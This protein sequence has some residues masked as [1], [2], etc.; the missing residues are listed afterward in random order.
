MMIKLNGIYKNYPG[1]QVL[2]GVDM[3]VSAGEFVSITGRSGSGKS[4]LLHILG[5]LDTASGGE[6]ILDGKPLP[7]TASETL[8]SRIRGE[9]IGFIFQSHN[10]IPALTALE[11]VA[12]PLIY[13]KI[14]KSQRILSAQKALDEVGMRDR[15][16]HLP[17]ELSGGQSQRVAIARALAAKPKLLLADEPCG[18]LDTENRRVIMTIFKTLRDKGNTILLI[19]HDPAE[20]EAADRKLTLVNGTLAPA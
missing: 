3:S 20:A 7:R 17:S 8:L 1:V 11:N 9:K 6:Y 2:R 16:H 4:T 13:K 19:T 5:C 15:A 10:L 12:L 18:S 14:P